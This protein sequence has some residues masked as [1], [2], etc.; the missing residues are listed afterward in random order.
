[1]RKAAECGSK[2]AKR[3]LFDILWDI[4]T[5]ESYSEMIGVAYEGTNANDPEMMCRLGRAYR[6]GNGVSKNLGIAADWMKKS[7][8]GRCS[9]AKGEYFD[10]L[11][12]IDTPESLSMMMEYA[13]SESSRGNIELKAKLARAYC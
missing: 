7:A 2:E 13:N 10:I 9:Y 1:M 4:G 11:W 12:D 5:P 3:G 8:D 6:W